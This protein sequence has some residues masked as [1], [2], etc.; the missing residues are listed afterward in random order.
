MK[1]L[2]GYDALLLYSQT[3]SV[4]THTMKIGVIDAGRKGL[5]FEQFRLLIAER[6]GLMEPLRYQLVDIPWKLHHPMWRENC[7]VDL[8]YHLK[9]VTAPGRGDRRSLDEVTAEIASTPLARDRPLWECHFV[10]GLEANRVAVIGKVHHALADGVASAN[11][12]ARAM[13][14]ARA[15]VAAVRSLPPP[16]PIPT[17]RELIAAAAR[18]HLDN[19]RTVPDLVGYTV[20]GITSVY[21][22]SRNRRRHPSMARILR[23][24][25]TFMNHVVS[26]RR[27][28]ASATL[29][30][31]DVKEV[32]KRLNVTI[33]T[34]VLGV[35]A[36]ALRELLLHY[37]GHADE[38]L[39][40]SVPSSLDLSPD[41]ISGNELGG[42]L[43][44]LP[45]QIDDPLER[46]RLTDLAADVA[47]ENYRLLGPEFTARWTTFVPPALA[48]A[49][50]AWLSRRDA[51][52]RIFNLPISNVPG[53]RQ[54]GRFGDLTL[55]EIYS[56]G[57]LTAGCALNITVWSY[58]DQ[59]NIS[60]LADDCTV[61]DPHEVTDALVREFGQIRCAAGYSD[62]ITPVPTAMALVG[63]RLG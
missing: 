8:D 27:T 4:Y 56:V 51:K 32:S 25:D 55:S 23:A 17:R 14:P 50:F 10:E 22:R 39:F 45:V 58:A 31:A 30:L 44:S 49:A 54:R 11:L 1:R 18:D 63:P 40:A 35:A 21:R 24:P 36:G 20:S 61:G 59:F 26:P 5:T 19:I 62:L 15:R 12:M 41:R 42:M 2:G 60:V 7:D 9:R 52:V 38:P 13:D 29:A 6:L 37:D 43:V 53:P 47:K 48:P 28:F 33:N 34:I 16:D 57:P 46:I 3:P